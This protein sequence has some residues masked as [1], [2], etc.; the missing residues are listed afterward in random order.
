MA[1][2]TN[3]AACL[4]REKLAASGLGDRF[5]AVVVSED[6]GLAKPETAIFE[7]ALATMSVDPARA[8][9]VGDHLTKDIEGALA[10]GLRAVWLNRDDAPRPQAPPDLIEISTLDDLPEALALL[11]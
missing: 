1:V 11:S 8:V 10:A 5:E 2:V 6:V 4:Q 3:G 9:M 7:H